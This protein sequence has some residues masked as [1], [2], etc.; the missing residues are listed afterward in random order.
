MTSLTRMIASSLLFALALGT[1]PAFADDDDDDDRRKGRG[2][3]S[4]YKIEYERGG[5][6]YEYKETRKGYKESLECDGIWRDIPRQKYEYEANGCKYKYEADRHGYEEKYECRRGWAGYGARPSPQPWGGTPA[7]SNAALGVLNGRC[8]HQL[9]GQIL[10]GVAGAAVGS[11]VGKGDGRTAAVIGGTILGAL[12]GGNIGRTMDQTDQNCIGQTLEHAP[13]RQTVRWND[14]DNGTQYAVTPVRTE[15]AG[16]ERY[17]R[18][19][20]T[21]VVIGGRAEQAYGTACRQPD[22]SWERVR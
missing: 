22:G 16:G 3:K 2:K 7:P 10:G 6:E 12:I 20:I 9:L 4:E 17:C 13:D 15:P 19:F 21:E 1:G 14:P 11:R 18:E 5:C 8:D